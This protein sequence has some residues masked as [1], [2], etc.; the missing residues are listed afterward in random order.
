VLF[1]T[2]TNVL[3]GVI[4]KNSLAQRLSPLKLFFL[5]LLI[6][7]IFAFA[8]KQKQKRKKDKQKR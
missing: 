2:T 4:G 8:K 6:F 1:E 3:V 5:L 7:L